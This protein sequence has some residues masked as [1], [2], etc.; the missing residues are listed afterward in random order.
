[1]AN[2][3]ASSID[4]RGKETTVGYDALNRVSTVRYGV[5]DSS[6]TST[7]SYGYDADDRPTSIT[8]SA[9]GTTTVAYDDFGEPTSVSTPQGTISYSYDAGGRLTGKTVAG[10]TPIS[11]GYTVADQLASVSQGSS[12]ASYSYDSDGRL[13]S[14]A[15]PGATQAYG[16][17]AASQLSSIDYTSG[18]TTLGS[19]SYTYDPAGRVVGESGSWARLQLPAAMTATYNA[20]N[21]ATTVSGISRTYDGAGNLTSDGS[22]AYGWNDRGQ[23]ASVTGPGGTQSYGYTPDGLRNQV[24]SGTSST[25][26]LWD[27]AGNQV[28]ELSGGSVVAHDMTAGLD[29]TLVRTDS[30]GSHTQ[31]TDQLG[32]VLATVDPTGTVETQN[33]YSPFG[34]QASSGSASADAPGFTGRTTSPVTGLQYNRDRYYDPSLGRFINQDPTGQLGGI[35]TYAYAG[36][37]PI[38]VTDPSGDGPPPGTG[39]PPRL[40]TGPGGNGPGGPGG[41]GGNGPPGPPPNHPCGWG[42]YLGWTAVGLGLLALTVASAGVGDVALAGI[43]G[44]GGAADAVGVGS[45][46]VGGLADGAAVAAGVGAT[47]ADCGG[48]LSVQCGLDV[49]SLGLGAVGMAGDVGLLGNP[50]WLNYTLNSISVELGAVSASQPG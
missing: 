12:S 27:L 43:A 37:D 8:D 20:L 40:G 49:A 36:G 24:T 14:A 38:N 21:Q 33:A 23:L 15:L 35:N 2:R 45:V 28:A 10:G 5:T 7:I 6:A 42:C 34:Q 9:D 16:Y 46:T 26:Y 30:T 25:S 18:S 29:N 11:Y 1:M 48:G 13:T 17:D 39:N 47:E 32:S 22:N 31:L 3:L 44:I 19:L 41:P 4:G 50:E